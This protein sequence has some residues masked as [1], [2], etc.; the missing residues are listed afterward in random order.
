MLTCVLTVGGLPVGW[1]P[2]TANAA[3]EPAVAIK[4]SDGTTSVNYDRNGSAQSVIIDKDL[5]IDYN[6]PL[7]AATVLIEGFVPGDVLKFTDTNEIKGVYNA[8]NGILKLTGAATA[9]QYIDALNSVLFTPASGKVSDRTIKFSLGSA[10]PFDGN[11]HFYE[12]IKNVVNGQE[13]AITWAN[14]KAAAENRNYFGRQGYLVTITD[15][16]ENNFVTE[17]AQGLGWIGAEDIQRKSGQ[18]RNTGDWRWVTGPEG[19]RDNK[20]GLQFYTGYYQI[21]HSAVGYANWDAGEPNDTGGNEYVAHIFGP[22]SGAKTGKWNDYA[23]NNAGVKGY[24]VEYGGMDNDNNIQISATKTVNFVDVTDLNQE[25]KTGDAL[26]QADYDD[27]SW[28]DYERALEKAQNILNQTSKTQ[29]DVDAA[30]EALKK[31]QDSLK[32]K[33]E[34]TK[35][36][37]DTVYTAKPAFSGVSAPGATVTVAVY[38]EAGNVVGQPVEV[39]AGPNGEWSYV[40]EPGLKD[41]KY[42]YEVSAKKDQLETTTGRKDLTVNTVLPELSID[43]PAIEKVTSAQPEITGSAEPGA[44]VTVAVSDESGTQIDVQNVTADPNGNWSFTPSKPLENGKNYKVEAATEKDTKVSKAAK[45]IQVDTTDHTALAGLEVN[46]WDGTKIP[47]SPP[48]NGATKYQAS[49]TNDVYSVTINPELFDPNS[50]IEI[51]LNGG[52]FTETA[53]G[54]ASDKLPLH[55]GENTIVVRVT[56]ADNN[57]KEYTITIYRE[58]SGS[59][60]GNNGNSGNSGNNGNNGGGSTTSPTPAPPSGN[61]AIDTSVNGNDTPFATGKTT[62]TDNGK[63]T[64]VQVDSSKLNDILS[65]GNGQKLAIQSPNEGN[66]SVDGLTAADV[67]KLADKKASL[68][69]G[70]QLAIYPVP[71]GQLDVGKIARQLGNAA[72]GDI[73]VHIDIKRSADAVIA[74][75]KNQAKSKGY[76]LLVDPVDLDM[77]FT[78]NGSTVRSGQLNGYAV[79]Y[80]AL[81][82]GVDPNRITTGVVVNP[83]GTVFHLPTVVTKIGNRYYAEI[84]DLRS[85]GTYSVIWNPQDFDDVRSHWAQRNVNNI[86]ARLDLEGNGNNTFSPNRNVT[87][88]EFAEIVVLGLG[89][90]RQEEPK[91]TFNDVHSDAWY[92]SAISI[93]SEFGIVLG[94]DDGA[95]RGNQNITREEG[96]AMIARGYQLIRPGHT[97]GEAEINSLLSGYG[98][99]SKVAK[100]AKPSVATLL[101][102][103]VVQGNAKELGPKSPMTR[104][105]TVA[106]MERLLKVTKLID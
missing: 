21:A 52:P 72:A 31:A 106:L 75:A 56:D 68:E 92:R 18:P 6:Q 98:D 42:T 62:T 37:G 84:H 51:S 65:G 96:M 82:E 11:G 36:G 29:A 46:S 77:T 2:L 104:A 76:D 17:K 71:G 80:I 24:I 99:G 54:T 41:G 15:Q 93:A 44:T 50:K 20:N 83:D 19:E 102:E 48:F 70:N 89:L 94:Y 27:N 101:S 78:H 85:S 55:A 9:Q 57:V 61:S 87:R 23:P 10:L 43:G 60:G 28:K 40:P 16:E 90:M 64:S 22:D 34:V 13:T 74:N 32:L 91:N 14:A 103:D 59:N 49:V 39:T 73:A 66:L 53:N 69:I 88:A 81:P 26:N 58:F 1:A 67:Q 105:E 33:L 45:E 95:F 25:I 8:K 5:S 30:A 63:Q 3:A 100:W 4:T 86:A 47:L 12:Y 79:K 38:D 7:D 35:P 97:I